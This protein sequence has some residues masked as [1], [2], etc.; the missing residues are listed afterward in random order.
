MPANSKDK[1]DYEKG[2][3]FVNH[4]LKEYTTIEYK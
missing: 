2:I 3:F 4:V 1:D